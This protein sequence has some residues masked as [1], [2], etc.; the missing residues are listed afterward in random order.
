MKPAGLLSAQPGVDKTIGVWACLLLLFAGITFS[1]IIPPFQSPDEFDHIKRAYFLT[2][3]QVVLEAPLGQSSGGMLDSGL[4]AYFAAYTVL[5][6]KPERKLSSD[7]VLAARSIRW[8]GVDVFS[9]APGTGYYFPLI[10]LPQAAGLATGELLGQTVERSYYLARLFSLLTIVGLLFLA[11]E[12]VTPSPFTLALLV[13]PMTLF[14]MSSASLDGVSTAL[15]IFSLAAF[16]RLTNKALLSPP[17]LYPSMLVCVALVTASRV[18]L[19]PMWAMVLLAALQHK[20]RRWTA[21]ALTAFALVVVWLLIAI[22]NNV[23]LRPALR[24]PPATVAVHYVQHPMQF[25]GLLGS[26]VLEPG[27]LV[28]YRDSFLGVLGWLDTRFSNGTYRALA[29]CLLALAALSVPWPRLKEQ[30]E[31]RALLLASAVAAVLLIYAALLVTWNPHPAQLIYGIQGRYF[32]VPALMIS[33]ALT[34]IPMRKQ[35]LSRSLSIGILILIAAFTLFCTPRLLIDRYYQA[36]SRQ[37][38]A[39]LSAP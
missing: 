9:P 11:F 8:S 38:S 3:G 17:G 31:S 21:A 30:W 16:L 7:E 37:S 22:A 13:I 28:S 15:A 24:T 32:L 27:M 5:P 34:V 29:I 10:Y 6:F 20:N 26:T 35:G 18:H 1:S 14:Q 36:D 23:D 19:M 33:Y 2:R 4:D 39:P 25:F 12:L